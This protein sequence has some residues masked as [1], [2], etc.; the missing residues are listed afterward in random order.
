M[1]LSLPAAK[2]KTLEVS[3]LATLFQNHGGFR[4]VQENSLYQKQLEGTACR[5]ESFPGTVVAGFVVWSSSWRL[6]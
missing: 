5:V 2:D 3:H 6:V 4:L 1:T